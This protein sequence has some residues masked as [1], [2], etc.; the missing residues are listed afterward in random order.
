MQFTQ[1][2]FLKN[3]YIVFDN[4]L[5]AETCDFLTN[6]MFLKKEAGYLEPPVSKGGKDTQCPKSWS[7]YGDPA[8]DTLLKQL[9]P[10]LS[11]LLG[12]ELLP[13]Y[14]YARIYEPGETLE[15]HVDR[16]SCEISGTMTL[17]FES[18]EDLWPIYVGTPGSKEKVGTPVMIGK[19]ELMMY[20]G[21]QVPH[22]RDA[23]EGKWQV[24][25]FFHYVRADGPHAKDH[26]FDGRPN[27]GICKS[28]KDY[29]TQTKRI[30]EYAVSKNAEPKNTILVDVDKQE[31]KIVS[32]SNNLKPFKFEI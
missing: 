13:A 19:G 8:F 12:L 5:S 31:A 21:E 23:F 15:W 6:Y 18:L 24:Q 1:E 32:S 16:P 3:K 29:E 28:S 20:Q 22:W 14:T 25:V 30:I 27:L 26:V 7:V 4:V 10:S 11:S 2:T 17:G 9:C